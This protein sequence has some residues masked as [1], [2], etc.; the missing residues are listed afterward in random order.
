MIKFVFL[1][2]SLL[3]PLQAWPDDF[4]NERA[5]AD[6]LILEEK[7]EQGIEIYRSLSVRGD[8]R[9][10]V[11]YGAYLGRVGK[12]EEAV[13]I[14]TDAAKSGDAEAQFRLG[15]VFLQMPS[16][17]I[18]EGIRWLEASAA[19]GYWRAKVTLETIKLQS[20]QPLPNQ[21][22]GRMNVAELSDFTYKTL[23]VSLLAM[24]GAL[25]CYKAKETE[26]ESV[27]APVAN[28]CKSIS[29][30]EYGE[31]IPLSESSAF[32]RDYMECI[33]IGAMKNQ[34]ISPEE[35]VNCTKAIQ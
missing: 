31:S 22:S 21:K 29:L 11:A 9:S 26:F 4:A 20:Q 24:P 27:F 23:K 1:L 6:K 14:L 30:V 17:K 7:Y 25:K 3:L 8:V 28:K 12:Y 34:Q 18:N 15:G 33:R 19:Q 35:L 5:R 13:K 2:I 10:Q 16:Q 32:S